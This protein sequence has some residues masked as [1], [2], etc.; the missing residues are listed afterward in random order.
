[1]ISSLRLVEVMTAIIHLK[2]DYIYQF[3][4]YRIEQ[5]LYETISPA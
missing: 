2:D 5:L 4:V 1:M 3:G